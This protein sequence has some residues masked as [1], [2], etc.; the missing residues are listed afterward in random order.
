MSAVKVK[1]HGPSMDMTAM[2]DVAFLLLTF[3][4]MASSFK[5]EETVSVE[6]P[7]SVSEELIPEKNIG[8]VTIDRTGKYYFGMLDP[9]ERD[10]YAKALSDEFQL[11]LTNEEIVKFTKLAEVGVPMKSLKGYLDLDDNARAA[12]ELSGIPCDSTDAELVKWVK[13]YATMKP[14]G[15]IAIKGDA[16]TQYPA[17]KT[18]FDEF[19]KAKL[20][21]FQLITKTEK[22]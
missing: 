10:D 16:D 21:K 11:G 3:F 12:V 1:R 14:D 19:G 13:T 18:L 6:T 9:T 7:S 4:I 2:C 8:M 15:K 5:S 20:N 22:K 17:I